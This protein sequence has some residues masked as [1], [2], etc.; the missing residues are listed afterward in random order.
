VNQAV[1]TTTIKSSLNPSLLGESVTL[2]ATATS[3]TTTP[4]GSVTFMDGT[5]ALGIVTLSGGKASY[6]TSTL[7]TGSHN[8]KAV[9]N[10]TANIVGSTSSAL[11]Q[12]VN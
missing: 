12:T 3:P 11:V 8:V 7:T 10:G 6:S 9:Y 5:N 4:T 2:T 1:S